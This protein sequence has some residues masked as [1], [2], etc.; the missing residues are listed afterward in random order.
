MFKLTKLIATGR[1]LTLTLILLR[2]HV[3]LGY[4]QWCVVCYISAYTTDNI[5]IFFN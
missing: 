5:M 3:V 1:A 4:V 2:E